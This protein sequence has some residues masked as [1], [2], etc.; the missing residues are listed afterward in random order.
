M[1]YGANRFGPGRRLAHALAGHARGALRLHARRARR[2]ARELLQPHPERGTDRD[3]GRGRAGQGRSRWPR[4][5]RSSSRRG[6]ARRPRGRD[7][8]ARLPA[9][10]GARGVRDAGAARRRLHATAARKSAEEL[11]WLADRLRR[12]PTTP[13][14]RSTGRPAAG[15]DERE[16]GEPRRARLRRPT[17]ARRTST[18]SGDAGVPGPSGP[19][20]A[21]LERGDVLDL[22]DQRLVLGLHRPAPAH[23]R[24]RRRPAAALPRAAR[25]GR[26]GV[27]RALRPRA[28]GRH[29]GRARRGLGA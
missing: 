6:A 7:R 28:P 2:P 24:D 22:R 14:A 21:A 11:D 23:L 20:R 9:P 3:R 18:T 5:S 4:R 17:A 13:C 1:I 25:R 29:R 16:L 27:R 15:I 12:S 10:R 26:R 19:R 8:P